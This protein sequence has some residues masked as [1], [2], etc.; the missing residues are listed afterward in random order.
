MPTN[1]FLEFCKYC[2]FIAEI[3]NFSRMKSFLLISYSVYSNLASDIFCHFTNCKLRVHCSRKS[4][5]STRQSFKSSCYARSITCVVSSE[6]E[7]AVLR[8][9]K[10]PTYEGVQRSCLTSHAASRP[11][12]HELLPKERCFAL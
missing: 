6:R 12:T 7:R 11:Q 3:I 9:G 2:E 1:F 5:K 10:K 4:Q 8:K